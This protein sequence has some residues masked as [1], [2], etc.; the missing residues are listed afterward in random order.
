MFRR[1]NTEAASE[2]DKTDAEWREQLTPQQYRVLRRGATDRA[3]SG[4]LWDRHDGGTYRCAACEAILFDS[5]AKYDSGTGWPSFTEPTVA[6]A[7]TLH[8]DIGLGGL[9]TEVRC[10]RCGGH[11]GHVFRDGPGPTGQR[12]CINDSALR[13]ADAH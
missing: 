1:R 4:P 11:L 13:V 9:R 8:R 12:F 2:V 5:R 3:F 6:E 7:V 10:R